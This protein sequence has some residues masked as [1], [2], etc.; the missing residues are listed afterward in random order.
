MKFPTMFSPVQIGSVTVPNRFVVP[1]MGNNFA[2]TDG[3]L[4]DRSLSYYEARAKGG[5]SLITI[6]STVVYE[7]AKGGPRKPCLFSD[8]TVESFRRVASACHAYGAKVSIQLQ[9]AGPEGSSALTGYP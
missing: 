9:H 7:Q 2:N 5:F 8:S 3:S 1:P 4:S 6:E